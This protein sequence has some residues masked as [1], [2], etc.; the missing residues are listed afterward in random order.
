MAQHPHTPGPWISDG[1]DVSGAI[2]GAAICT[3]MEAD[4]FPCLEEGTEADVQAECEANVRLIAAAP[5]L[6][7]ELKRLARAYVSLMEAGRDRIIQLGGD[8]DPVDVM[9]AGNPYLRDAKAVIAK[10]EGRP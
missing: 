8:C 1:F 6:L 10:A 9:E 2:S 4:H 3:V 7:S 5:D